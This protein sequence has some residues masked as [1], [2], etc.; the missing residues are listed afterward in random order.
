MDKVI[1]FRCLTIEPSNK[2]GMGR[3]PEIGDVEYMVEPS[4]YGSG[5]ANGTTYNT[6]FSVEKCYGKG[7]PLML[8]DYEY[9]D[10]PF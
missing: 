5:L 9:D 1:D 4:V 8:D 3:A 6:Y 2:Y 10:K 7:N